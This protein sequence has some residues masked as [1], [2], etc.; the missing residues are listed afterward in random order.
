MSETAVSP[1]LQ[2]LNP[3]IVWKEAENLP[4]ADGNPFEA[5][6]SRQ[7]EAGVKYR[8]ANG[9]SRRSKYFSYMAVYCRYSWNGNWQSCLRRKFRNRL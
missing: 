6:K 2:S 7:F 9:R 1:L 4:Y 8:P 5:T 3:G